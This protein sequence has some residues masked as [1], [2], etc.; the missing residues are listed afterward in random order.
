MKSIVLP[1]ETTRASC[2]TCGKFVRAT[3]GYRPYTLEDDL[4]VE[5]VMC[6]TC[7][8]CGQV[9]GVAQQSAYLLRRALENE[10]RFRTTLRLP[11]ELKDYVALQLDRLGIAGAPQS[12][13]QLF[14]RTL[15][16]ACRGKENEVAQGLRDLADPVLERPC[17][18][19]L[20]LTLSRPLLEVL[21]TLKSRTGLD[22]S[23]EVMRRLLVFSDLQP[24]GFRALTD[25]AEQVILA[26]A[27]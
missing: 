20:T 18:E 7:P 4:V 15:L 17:T 9:V 10:R 27:V 6:A 24:E 1:G 14:L 22:N 21:D 12:Y 3:W 26:A 13:V 16:A 23:S 11:Q 5:Q 8:S 19:M 25:Q 2:E